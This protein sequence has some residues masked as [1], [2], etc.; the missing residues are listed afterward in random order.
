MPGFFQLP[1][2]DGDGNALWTGCQSQPMQVWRRFLP[3]VHNANA[4]IAL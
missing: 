2:D 1:T 4:L 3:H